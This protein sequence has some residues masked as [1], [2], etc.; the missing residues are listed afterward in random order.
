MGAMVSR[1]RRP[2]RLLMTTDAVGG[3]WTYSLEL[4]RALAGQ[5]VEVALAILGP[6]PCPSQMF[7]AE[8][9]PNCRVFQH[10]TKL[11]WMDVPWEDV[12]AAGK[13]L[14]ALAEDFVPD[15]VHLNDYSHA[16]LPWS[17]PVVAVAHSC[18]LTWWRSVKGENAPAR[19][20]EYRHRVCA[21]LKAANSVVTP[22]A[23]FRT[24]MTKEY[25]LQFR[26]ETIPNARWAESFGPGI[27]EPRII[28][29]GRLWDEA[30]N[31]QLLDRIAPEVTWEIVLAGEPE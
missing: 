2:M 26:G 31:L 9:L 18:V 8:R 14:I 28:S 6:R 24:Q 19:Y 12:D 16:S 25:S 10:G 20:D 7:E 13:W 11:E 22:T 3:V 29:A 17:C 21:A 1:L 5:D 27:T 4:I 15:V 30:K 23:A